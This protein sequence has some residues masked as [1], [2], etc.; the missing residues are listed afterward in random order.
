MRIGFL[1]NHYAPH[2]VPH[3]APIAFALSRLRPEWHVEVMCS[4]PAEAD[5]AAEIATLYPGHG[6]AISRLRVPLLARAV[7]P[8]VRQVAFYRKLAVQ[9]ANMDLFASFDALAVPEMTSLSLRADPRMA[10]VRLIFTGHGAG[11]GYGRAVGMFDPRID[12]FDLA[13]LPG[14]RIA[15]E[16]AALGRFR[17]CRHAVVG[18][19]K[20]EIAALGQGRDLFGNGRPT[21]LYNPTQTRAAS[22]WFRFGPAVLDFFI[23]SREYNLIF[24]PHVLLF[25]RSWTRGARLPRRFR[26]TGTVLIDTG[27][28]ASVD[29]SYLQAADIYLGDLSSQVYEFVARPRPCVFLDPIG[30]DYRD[31]PG[32]RSW[33]FGPVV[34]DVAHLGEALRR[35]AAEF[36]RYRPLQEEA[37][38]RNFA[39]SPVPASTRSA[40]A[41][42]AF[43]ETGEVTEAA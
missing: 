22:S 3:V 18:Y 20:L 28:R 6:A 10:G 17:H 37:R 19:P 42:A 12:L 14:P 31:D 38:D 33:S 7:D 8:L 27:S 41:I 29:L 24:A 16:L 26:S 13:L 35:A 11:D 4:T 32:F 23:A 30:V 40:M 2:Q 34:R 25:K 36:P 15:G 43:V 9:R 5:F 1:L 39:P 21:V